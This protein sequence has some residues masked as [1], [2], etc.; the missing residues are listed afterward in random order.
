MKSKGFL[1]MLGATSIWGSVPLMGIWSG[2]PSG[3]FVFFRVLFAFPFVFYFAVRKSSLKEFFNLKPYWPLLLSGIMLGVNWV[4]FF[5]AVKVTD[6]ATVVTIYYAGPVISILLAAF[7][8]KERM[9]LFTVVSI[10]LA[11]AGVVVSSGGFNIDK[12]AV[13]ALLA[14][15]FLDFSQKFPPFIIKQLQLPPGRYLYPSLLLFL[16]YS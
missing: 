15:G 13:I 5:W 2:L 7:F 14:T 9:N 12:G 8:L 1:E 10:F 4:F 16:F 6:I 11:F 3:V